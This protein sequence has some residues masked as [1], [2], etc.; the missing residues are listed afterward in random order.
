MLLHLEVIQQRQ[1]LCESAPETAYKT[2][3][4]EGA[5]VT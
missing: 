5:E 2:M 1:N 3:K 4:D